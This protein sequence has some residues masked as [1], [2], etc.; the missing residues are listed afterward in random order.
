VDAKAYLDQAGFRYEE[1]NV[2][3]DSKAYSEMIRLSGQSYTPT[4]VVGGL[5]LGDFGNDELETFL[6]KHDLKPY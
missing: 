2:L 5:V 4:L 6:Q 3:A 1:I